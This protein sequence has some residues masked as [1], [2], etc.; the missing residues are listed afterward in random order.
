MDSMTDQARDVIGGVDAHVDSHHAAALDAHGR[1]LGSAGFPAT[2]AGYHDLCDWLSSFGTLRLVGV[3]STGSYGAGLTRLL[4]P[5]GV[6]VVEINQPPRATRR[7]RGKSDAIDAEAAAR[8]A[9]ATHTPTIP[10]DTSG[11]VEAIR[12][13]RVA[14]D[15][16]VRA[17]AAAY[18]QLFEL[19]V[20]APDELRCQLTRKT[21]PGQASLCARLRPDQTH[22]DQP[23]HATKLAL[24]SVA[25]RSIAL[26]QQ[27]HDLDVHLTQLVAATAPRTTALLG[28]TTGHAGAL[29]VAAGQNIDRLRSEAAFSHLCAANPIPASSGRTHRHR[30]NRGG[31]RQANRAL[32]MIVIVRLRYCPRTQAY[33]ARRTSEG[34]T[35]REII[36]CLKR[37][38]ARELYHTLRA[39]LLNP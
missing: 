32:H 15:G 23:F 24:R 10:K 7:L 27:V 2:S 26:D 13:L 6:S 1:L 39:D 38:V 8:Q 28:V 4:Q 36:R 5:Q 35:K 34:L 20:T 19:I 12:M 21:L 11:V 37:F 33:A 14:R 31:N 3:E 22:L 18:N 30:L 16:A 17:R 9:L 29:L 25:Q